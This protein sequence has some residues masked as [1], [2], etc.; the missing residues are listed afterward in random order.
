MWF[1]ERFRL[2]AFDTKSQSQMGTVSMVPVFDRSKLQLLFWVLNQ[3]RNFR[4]SR[5]DPNSSVTIWNGGTQ[6]EATLKG[7]LVKWHTQSFY[8]TQ[9]FKMLLWNCPLQRIRWYIKA[10]KIWQ[11]AKTD[12][13][14]SFYATIIQDCV[15]HKILLG[16]DLHL[17]GFHSNSK[18][19]D[20]RDCV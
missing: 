10:D 20:C 3:V 1:V 12:R 4:P 14:L 7:N 15:R 19:E 8:F 18:I 2:Y 13:H 17:A 5:H 9:G 16:V 6:S 11:L